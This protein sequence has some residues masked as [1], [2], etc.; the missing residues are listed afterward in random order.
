LRIVYIPPKI[1]K[2]ENLPS[3][4]DMPFLD[5]PL[6]IRL[7]VYSYIA[8]PTSGPFSDY[9]GLYLS[10]QQIKAEINEEAPK[11]CR[12]FLDRFSL[13]NPGHL[14]EYGVT[15]PGLYDLHLTL[16]Y[17]TSGQHSVSLESFKSILSLHYT[18]VTITIRPE[19]TIARSSH[20]FSRTSQVAYASQIALDL[21]KLLAHA[22]ELIHVQRIVLKL[23]TMDIIMNEMWSRSLEI[24]Y[25]KMTMEVERILYKP[26]H[27]ILIWSQCPTVE[28]M[29]RTLY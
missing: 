1:S 23:P 14:F 2:Y 4:N 3:S 26:G 28:S 19:D 20:A 17:H 11:I 13:A 27:G 24:P 15:L 10:C 16:D 8:F 7:H 9:R 5:I 29:K 25:W 21:T 6:E 22:D 18:S 12:S